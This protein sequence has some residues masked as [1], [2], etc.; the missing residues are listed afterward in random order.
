MGTC[1]HVRL[2]LPWSDLLTE[3][4]NGCRHGPL[5][6]KFYKKEEIVLF[7]LP[8]RDF[9]VIIT[10]HPTEPSATRAAHGDGF[11]QRRRVHGLKLETPNQCRVT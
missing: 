5:Q 4:L 11:T 3:T 7:H 2:L 10:V 6:Y 9:S 8:L 1:K